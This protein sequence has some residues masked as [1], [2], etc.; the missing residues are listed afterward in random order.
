MDVRTYVRPLGLRTAWKQRRQRIFEAQKKDEKVDS[1]ATGGR[2][3]NSTKSLPA[4]KKAGQASAKAHS[5]V[6]TTQLLLSD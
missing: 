6:R 4:E 2:K 1:G 3:K 5:P